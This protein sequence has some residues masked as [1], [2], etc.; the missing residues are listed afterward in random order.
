MALRTGEFYP[1]TGDL[2]IGYS[3]KFVAASTPDIHAAALLKNGHRRRDIH[4]TFWGTL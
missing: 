3:E 4:R 2:F 1:R